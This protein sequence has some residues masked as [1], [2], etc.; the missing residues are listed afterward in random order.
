MDKF[1][2]THIYNQLNKH[3]L[4]N[5]HSQPKQHLA[6]IPSENTKVA[7]VR[8]GSIYPFWKPVSLALFLVIFLLWMWLI[9]SSL[10]L[11]FEQQLK[12]FA[13]V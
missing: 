11:P 3:K 2:R 4:V 9:A 6:L 13:R 12:M 8:R 7:L 10:G 5:N 1:E